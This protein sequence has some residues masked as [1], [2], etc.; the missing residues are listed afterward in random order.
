MPVALDWLDSDPGLARLHGLPRFEAMRR[1][2]ETALDHLLDLL[3]AARQRGELP[4]YLESTL[5]QEHARRGA[6]ARQ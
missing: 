3:D 6:A 5:T 4:G 2:A 1:Q